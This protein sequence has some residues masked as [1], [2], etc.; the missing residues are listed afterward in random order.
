MDYGSWLKAQGVK[1]ISRSIHYIKQS[2]LKGSL[3]ETRG[4]ILRELA[5]AE[6]V[7]TE[8]IRMRVGMDDRF[9]RALAG[10]IRDRLV[11]RQGGRIT[12]FQ[13]DARKV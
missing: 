13:E 8:E 1:N 5:Q 3:R 11:A 7:R 12:L 6:S 2:P 4:V 10:L 9:E